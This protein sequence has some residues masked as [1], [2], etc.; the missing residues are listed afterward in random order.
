MIR[1]HNR[2]KSIGFF[3]MSP[4]FRMFGKD[5]NQKLNSMFLCGSIFNAFD[6]TQYLVQIDSFEI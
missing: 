6:L 1:V 3:S 5:L 2:K 4:K